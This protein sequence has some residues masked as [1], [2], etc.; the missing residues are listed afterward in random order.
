MPVLPTLESS[1]SVFSNTTLKP[2]DIQANP[3]AFGA[4]TGEALQGV[5]QAAQQVS[6]EALDIA[7]RQANIQRETNTNDLFYKSFFPSVTDVTQKYLAT[8]GKDAVDA[9]P[10]YQQSLETLREQQRSTLTDPVEQR[11]FDDLSRRVVAFNV[12]G[13][14]RHATQQNQVYRQQTSDGM[15]FAAQQSAAGHWND[16]NAFNGDLASIAAE[17]TAHG[18]SSGEPVEY[19][20]AKIQHD[21]SAS[22]VD[23]LKGIASAGDASTALTLLNQGENYTDTAGNQRHTDVRSQILPNDLVALHSELS[24]HAAD[25]IGVS[26]GNTATAPPATSSRLVDAFMGQESSGGKNAGVS[27]NGARGAMQI[28]QDTFNQY[29]KPGESID[30]PADNKAV[31]ARIL[32]DYTKKYNGDPAKIAVAYFSG[33]GNVSTSGPTP[34]KNNTQDGNGTTVEQYVQGILGRMAKSQ[35]PG[36]AAGAVSGTLPVG[37][38]AGVPNAAS[39]SPQP[40]GVAQNPEQMRMNQEAAASNAQQAAEA[41]VLQLTGDPVAAKRAGQVAAS[42]VASNTNSQIALQQTQQRI[43]SGT[44]AQAMAGA[45]ATFAKP[46]RGVPGSAKQPITNDTQ[47][48]SDPVAYANFRQM[49]PEGQ[50]AVTERLTN[51]GAMHMTQDSLN[52]YYK[53]K[54]MSADDPE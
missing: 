39:I 9:Y 10:A 30:N 54:G 19:T 43:A 32:D 15:V 47:L 44:V 23:R 38:A 27:V 11:M 12:D 24:T 46:M 25:Q 6:G 8:Q 21:V 35:P 48:V 17:R 40:V 28:T 51:P 42:T 45:R 34:W 50:A 14:A 41:H 29:A 2:Q 13:A 33:P 31:G 22:W 37:N 53:L 26:Y 1:Q 20:N 3:S 52:T 4:A 49:S 16:A 7:Q 36:A 18:M 5:G